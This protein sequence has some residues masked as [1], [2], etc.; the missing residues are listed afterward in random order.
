MIETYRMLDK[1]I[2]EGA[3]ETRGHKTLSR[4]IKAGTK[5]AIWLSKKV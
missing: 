3:E 5:L 4:A 2:E 1:A